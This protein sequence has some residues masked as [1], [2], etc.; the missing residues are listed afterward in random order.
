MASVGEAVLC[1][2]CC[3]F[4][5]SS[6]ICVSNSVLFVTCG[7]A[8]FTGDKF[9][10]LSVLRSCVLSAAALGGVKM[11]CSECVDAEDAL[12]LCFGE[13]KTDGDTWEIARGCVIFANAEEE[14]EEESKD[15]E[16]RGVRMPL[17]E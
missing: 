13:N 7:S 9:D 17:R 2:D 8:L 10:A 6:P 16:L 1:S 14:E 3:V 15:D 4:L 12:I 11:P 5:L